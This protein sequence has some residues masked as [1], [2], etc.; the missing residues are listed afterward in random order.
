MRAFKLNPEALSAVSSQL[1]LKRW[2]KR[3]D[4][5]KPE[6]G[7]AIGKI[8]GSWYNT[9]RPVLPQSELRA[10]KRAMILKRETMSRLK[11]QK[12]E[13]EKIRR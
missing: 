11:K 5:I 4:P 8:R 6:I 13:R 1:W 10:A 12:T 2:N 7:I 9:N 3:S